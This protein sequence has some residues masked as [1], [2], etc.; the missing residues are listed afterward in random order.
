[1]KEINENFK[2]KLEEIE[3]TLLDGQIIEMDASGM[4]NGGL[5]N[6]KDGETWFGTSKSENNKII[7]DFVINMPNKNKSE[8]SSTVFKIFFDNKLKD[9]FLEYCLNE[10]NQSYLFIKLEQK[11]VSIYYNIENN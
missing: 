11:F 4:S 3:G 6:A 2:L 5:R 10:N 8:T 1:M 7:N 9:Y